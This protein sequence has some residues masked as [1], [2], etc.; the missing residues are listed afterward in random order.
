MLRGRRSQAEEGRVQVKGGD[1][2]QQAGVGDHTEASQRLDLLPAVELLPQGRSHLGQGLPEV[3]RG[4]QRGEGGFVFS[5]NSMTLSQL[6]SGAQFSGLNQNPSNTHFFLG[7]LRV[8]RE[9]WSLRLGSDWTR[10]DCESP[11]SAGAS[12]RRQC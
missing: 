3:G 1:Q 11:R 5:S 10:K 8:T 7:S 12:N 2:R 6:L 9:F 4:G